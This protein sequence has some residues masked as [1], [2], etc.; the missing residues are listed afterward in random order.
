MI[1]KCRNTEKRF[2]IKAVTVVTGAALFF[3]VSSG[4]NFSQEKNKYVGVNTCV[5]SCHKSESQGN[6]FLIWKESKHADAFLTLRT[7]K[8]DSIALSKGIN[9]AASESPECVKCHTTGR[10]IIE[11]EFKASF[12]L[13]QG[14][15][16]ESCHG[17]GSG[18]SKLSI[19]K[20]KKKAEENGLIIH[21]EKKAFCITCHNPE[22]PTYFEFDYDPMW[23]MIAHPKSKE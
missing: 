19:M 9:T 4:I 14:V 8:A 21:K 17:P 18:Y 5:G 12:D 13:T 2:I 1:K 10:E 6:Q 20:D 3:F 16:C 15:Q 7:E 22:S 23:E 11:S